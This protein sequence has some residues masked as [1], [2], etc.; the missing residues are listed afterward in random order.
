MNI[1]FKES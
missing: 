1:T